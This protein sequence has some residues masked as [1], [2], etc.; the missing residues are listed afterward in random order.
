MKQK[1]FPFDIIIRALNIHMK[2]HMRQFVFLKINLKQEHHKSSKGKFNKNIQPNRHIYKF[3]WE[4]D[5]NET[6]VK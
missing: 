5:M 4:L 2:V 6:D 3:K 1:I